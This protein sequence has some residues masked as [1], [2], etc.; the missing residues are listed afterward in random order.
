MTTSV[1]VLFA[2]VLGKLVENILYTLN[3]HIQ[4][5]D[6]KIRKPAVLFSTFVLPEPTDTK[7]T[8]FWSKTKVLCCYRYVAWL[9][10][11]FFNHIFLSFSPQTRVGNICFVKHSPSE[12]F[13][14]M[15]RK[16]ETIPSC[17]P[18]K[19]EMEISALE[20]STLQFLFK[21]GQVT[22]TGHG[23]LVSCEQYV[24]T[25]RKTPLCNVGQ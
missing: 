18:T 4:G 21:L 12:T 1:S 24:Q 6:R 22:Q 19:L 11:H 20:S 14:L 23:P 3:Y 7:R 25:L 13:A 10:S 17:F 9:E 15:K 2:I 8:Q 16:E 5:L